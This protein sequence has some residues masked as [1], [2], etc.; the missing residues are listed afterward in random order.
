MTPLY[1]VILYHPLDNKTN[2]Y[3]SK[4]LKDKRLFFSNL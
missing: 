3:S 2:K 4:Y 1:S